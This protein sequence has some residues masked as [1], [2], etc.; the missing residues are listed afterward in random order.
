MDSM[1]DYFDVTNAYVLN[2][3]RIILLPVTIKVKMLLSNYVR[4]MTGKERVLDK[5][6]TIKF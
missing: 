1:K 4:A 6:S 2:K 5:I 3:L